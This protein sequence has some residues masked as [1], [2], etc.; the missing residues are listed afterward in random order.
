MKSFIIRHFV[1]KQ[2]DFVKIKGLKIIEVQNIVKQYTESVQDSLV[3]YL[4]KL[5]QKDQKFARK[6]IAL[7]EQFDNV[8][9]NNYKMSAF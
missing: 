3:A 7:S 4:I 8:L 5:E 6:M 2:N 1:T 9:Y